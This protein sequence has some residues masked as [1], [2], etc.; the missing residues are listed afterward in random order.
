MAVISTFYGINPVLALAVI[1]ALLSFLFALM[2]M[3][4]TD[5]I[6]MRY[7]KGEMTKLKEQIKKAQSAKKE[8]ELKKLWEKSI[9]INSQ[10]M[11]MSM[12]P[13]MGSVIVVLFAFPFIAKAFAELSV[14]LPFGIPLL[15][16][17]GYVG[18][19]GFYIII[20]IPATIIS[21]KLLGIDY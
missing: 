18:W 10:F 6:K 1:A 3:K 20:S 16:S 19:L 21:R 14:K 15:A 17:S 11:K 5:P 9:N 7:L 8:K 13:M 2:Q 12:K 4:F